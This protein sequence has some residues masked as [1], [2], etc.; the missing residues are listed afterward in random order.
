MSIISHIKKILSIGDYAKR[1]KHFSAIR[2]NNLT[3]IPMNEIGNIEIFKNLMTAKNA[4]EGQHNIRMFDIQDDWFGLPRH[5]SLLQLRSDNIIDERSLGHPISGNLKATLWD[6]QQQAMKEFESGLQ[7]DKT[8]FFLE[9]A[10][11]SGKTIMGLAMLLSLGKTALIVVPKT[12][13]VEQWLDRIISHTTIRRDAVGLAQDGK[14]D[15]EGKQIVIGL[16]HTLV[17]D[18]WGKTFRDHFGTILY[19]ECDS[20]I[21]PRTFN[22]IGSMFPAKYRIGMTASATRMDNMHRVFE[23]H[24][25]EQHIKCSNT[26]TLPAKINMIGYHFASGQQPLGGSALSRRGMILSQL[27]NNDHRTNFIGACVQDAYAKEHSILVISDR[28]EQLKNLETILRRKGIPSKEIGYYVASLDSEKYKKDKLKKNADTCRIL[29]GTY[30]MIKR[31]T[32]IPRLSC[33]ILATPQSDLRQ[34]KGRIERFM[35]YK[36][37]PEIYDI[38][39]TFYKETRSSAH[40]RLTLYKNQ[41][42]QINKINYR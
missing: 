9:A 42:A 39:D 6:Y 21:P 13:L 24:L 18:R 15:W 30:G 35:D 34:T 12:D 8:G 27:A 19:D 17:K 32:D 4:F 7:Q 20:S 2:I 22:A 28:K 14:C 26:K 29:L 41:N 16:V 31:G 37:E 1:P 11:G 3:Y 40:S 36:K 25:L 33:L 5:Q 10:P 23:M 38:V